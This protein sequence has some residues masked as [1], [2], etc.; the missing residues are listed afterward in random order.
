[1]PALTLDAQLPRRYLLHRG[2]VY[3]PSDPFATAML[4]IDGTVAWIGSDA[5]AA[6]HADSVD[7]MFDLEGSLV[8]PAF[9]DAHVHLTAL[10]LSLTGLDLSGVSGPEELLLRLADTA[11][12]QSLTAVIWGHGWDDSAWTAALPT[13]QQ[14]DAA[15]GG[16]AVFL[17]RVDAHSALVS[18]A[19]VERNS[20]VRQAD[21]FDAEGAVSR[22][23]NLILRAVASESIPD[24]QR[25]ASQLAALQRA[26]SRGIASVHEMGGPG[27]SSA[28][29][30]S[31]ALAL[32]QHP[33]HV[34]VIG[35]W[36]EVLGLER[37]ADLGAHGCAG[38]LFVDGSLGSHTACLREPYVDEPTTQGVAYLEAEVI[39]EHVR[40]CTN[41]GIQAGFHV[42]GDAAM[43][44]VIA[45]F[46]GA[47]SQ[48]G[49]EAM[50]RCGHRLEHAEMLDSDALTTLARWGVTTSMQ[51][52]FDAAWGGAG[53]MYVD[54]LGAERARTL[55][56]F[57]AVLQHGVPLAFGSDAPVTALE[58]WAAVR[59]AAFHHQPEHRIST[60][61][62]F[63]AHTRGGRR[64]AR[65]ESQEP[66]VLQEGTPAT[67]AV[68]ADTELRVIAPDDRIAAWSTDPRSGTPGLPDLTPG[69]PEPH[70][71]GTVRAGQVL[72]DGTNSG[73]GL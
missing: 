20:H 65:Q 16:R 43:D 35:Y 33:G 27:I 68:W 14:I 67:F 29:D 46:L 72:F 69:T 28:L 31:S 22:D 1:M 10:G 64:A 73:E 59:A 15:S 51:P 71:R 41:A 61:A 9:V 3:S 24:G 66:G 53:G 44:R 21:G 40:A 63:A 26:A 19:L 36:G 30:L 38:D 25:H 57:A 6:V 32:G 39:A 54:R 70:C 56:P 5:G 11:K 34:E 13:R 7:A 58:P 55:N 60:R 49:D 2:H 50:R 17:S 45:G 48:V 47:A 37:A 8:T 42:I 23:A 18:S 52:S 12:D 4:V 62:A